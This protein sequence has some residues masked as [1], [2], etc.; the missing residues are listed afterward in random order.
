MLDLKD[1][2]WAVAI[3]L[4]VAVSLLFAVSGCGTIMNGAVPSDQR[5][6]LDVVALICDIFFWGGLGIIIDLVTGG[7]W[8]RKASPEPAKTTP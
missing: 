4:L 2:R 8:E 6:E 7:L 5:G 3:I 1:S